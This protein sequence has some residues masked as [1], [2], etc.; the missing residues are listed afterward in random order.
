ME[1]KIREATPKDALGIVKV[2][3]QTWLDTYPNEELKITKEAIDESY[4]DSYKLE[5]I[6]RLQEKLKNIPNNQKR[7]VAESDGEIVA[8][9]TGVIKNDFNELKTIYVL[10]SFQGKGIGKKLWNETLKF[11]NESKKIIVKVATYN[12]NA[13]EFYKKLG[14]V[15]T[16]KRFF[17][18][19]LTDRTKINI[20]E[21]EMVLEKF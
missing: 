12:K 18:D 19:D 20:P 16:G 1:I 15:D 17:D 3:H 6:E 7:L 10:P 2:F 4:K 13:I 8:V 11:F 9:S 5:N 21:M 14:F